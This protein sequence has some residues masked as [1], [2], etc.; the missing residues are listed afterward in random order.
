MKDTQNN[1]V[2]PDQQK[3][4]K[5]D[6]QARKFQLTINNPEEKNLSHEAIKSKLGNLKPVIYFCLADEIGAETHTPH[7]HIF[8]YCHSPV[9]FSR[10]KKLF[11]EAHIEIAHGTCKENKEYVEKSGKWTEDK[12]ADT[13]VSGTFEEWGEMPAERESGGIRSD[14]ERLV[15]LIEAGLSNAE[16]IEND[17]NL[18]IHI[19]KIDKI[20]QDILEA[21]YKHTFRNLNV[22]YIWGPT[23]TGKTRFVMETEGYGNVYRVTDYQHPF[24]RYAQEPVLL[25]DEYRSNLV[26]GALLNYLDGYPQNLP[27]RYAPRAACYEV[28]YI[29]SNI[30]LKKQYVNI[31]IEEPESWRALLRRIHHV[32]EYRKDGPPID[33]GPAEEYVFPKLPSWV[34]EAQKMKPEQ[35]ELP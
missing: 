10:I 34:E 33:H 5:R 4:Q 19:S 26:L 16:I 20:R 13:A 14:M 32:I 18:A 7:T 1:Q 23:G 17:Q 25:L 27:A 8:L 35:M 9:R 30:D 15:S 24:D 11:P 28:V 21:R 29:V 12:K 2:L 3:G 31:Q 6:P 22:T